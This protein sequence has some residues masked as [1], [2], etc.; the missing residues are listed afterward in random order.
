M[1]QQPTRGRLSGIRPPAP[2]TSTASRPSQVVPTPQAASNVPTTLPPPAAPETK[3]KEKTPEKHIQPPQEIRKPGAIP[4]VAT[5][6]SPARVPSIPSDSREVDALKNKVKDLEEKL[7]TI[8]LKRAEDRNKLKEYEKCKI[9]LQQLLEFRKQ[10]TEAQSDLQKQLALAKKEAKEATEA[11]LKQMDDM[12]DLEEAAEMATLDREMAEEK[13]EQAAREIEQFKE[14][15]E[16]VTLDYEIMKNEIESKGAD[17]ATSYQLKQLEQQN[18]KLKEALIRLRDLSTEDKAEIHKLQ[19]ELDVTKTQNIELQKS[20]EKL[21]QEIRAFE[22]QVV[23]LK[24][25]VDFALGSQEM[26]E[27]LTEKNLKLEDDI[28]KEREDREVLEKLLETNEQ[29]LESAKETEQELLQEVDMHRSRLNEVFI[30]L[31]QSQKAIDD[32]EGTLLKFR[33]LVTKL[34]EENEQLKYRTNESH[35]VA[36]AVQEHD[37][38]NVEF[39]IRFQEQKAKSIEA[40][41]KKME[42]MRAEDQKELMARVETV[43]QMNEQLE[44][45]KIKLEGKEGEIQSLKRALKQKIDEASEHQIRKEIA[46]KKLLTANK[47][48][49]ERVTRMQTDLDSIKTTMRSK[50]KEFEETMSHL[51]ADIDALESERGE[52]KDKVKNLSSKTFYEDIPK[53]STPLKIGSAGTGSS[54]TWSPNLSAVEESYVQQICSLKRAFRSVKQENDKLKTKAALK[55]LEITSPS[56]QM[57]AQTTPNWLLKAQG[58]EQLL[59]QHQEKLDKLKS[60]INNLSREV[61]SEIISDKLYDLRQE[62]PKSIQTQRREE[63]LREKL[64]VSKYRQVEKEVAKFLSEYQNEG[65]V[66]KSLDTNPSISGM[67]NLITEAEPVLAARITLPL[68]ADF[69]KSDQHK[70]HFSLE[71]THDQLRRLHQSFLN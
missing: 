15:L 6:P 39:K 59:D 7:E 24:E 32:H 68:L 64:L 69:S 56:V 35:Q 50:E 43:K 61:R 47:D 10:M 16:E 41:L 45:L 9:Q 66:G 4:S 36:Q 58:K 27:N 60:V 34:K 18:E 8:M 54:S 19:K 42:E 67:K 37:M 62:Q 11:R 52:L 40:E 2:R 51:Q 20:K 3:E 53:S 33:D 25:Q 17:V 38:E 21:S 31:D 55:Q 14:K 48:A 70:D 65:T 12:R 57:I 46:E 1:S 28:E 71:V 44:E 5:P 49:D 22:E 26:I 30:R 29:L 63:I 13:Y 23:D